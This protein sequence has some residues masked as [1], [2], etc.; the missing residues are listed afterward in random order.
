MVGVMQLQATDTRL[1]GGGA[2][3]SGSFS[4]RPRM[5][6]PVRVCGGGETAAVGT[7][8]LGLRA[9]CIGER[10]GGAMHGGASRH[11]YGGCAVSVRTITMAVI[12]LGLLD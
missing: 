11:Y 2:V 1:Q 6:T 8:H 4:S 7:I 10:W 12:L 3:W 9:A 5:Q